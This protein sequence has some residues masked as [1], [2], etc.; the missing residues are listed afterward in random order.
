M[1]LTGL[2]PSYGGTCPKTGCG[3]P[4]SYVV[5]LS[6]FSGRRSEMIACFVDIGES[7]DHHC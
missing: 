6:V 3:L 2:T 1:T 7:V 4:T 5:V